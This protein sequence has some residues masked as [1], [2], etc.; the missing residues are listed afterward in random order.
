MRSFALKGDIGYSRSR[1]ELCTVTDGYAVCAGGV[2]RGVFQTLPEE[3][4]GLPVRDFTGKLILPGMVDLHIHAP[5]FE[6]RG[7]GMDLELIEWLEQRTFPVEEKYQDTEYA[8]QAYGIFA[9]QMRK[10]ATTRACIFATPHREATEVL[11]E[12][13]E[14]TGLVTYVGKVNMDRGAPAGL[15]EAGPQ[16]AAADTLG[17]IERVLG[18]YEKT[19]PILTPRF[20]PGCSE[21]L[22]AELH[23]IQAACK[24]PVQSHLSENP[25]EVELVKKLHPGIRF[26][27]Q[28][29]DR[30]GLFG[31]EAKTVMAHC[32]YSSEEEVALM[33]KNGVFAAHCPASNMN[34]SSGIAP[35]RKYLE[36]GLRVGLGSD[37]A[38]GQTESMFRAI[39]D[40]VQVSKLYWRLADQ[41]SRPLT[42]AEAFYLATLGGGEFF[43]KTGSFEAGYEFDAIVLDEKAIPSPRHNELQERIERAVYLSAD[44]TGLRAKIVRGEDVFTRGEGG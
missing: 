12:Q 36:A 8:R 22:L 33:K 42:F 39:T 4:S 34:L 29:Y 37:V 26:Y 25:G 27:G 30:F 32:V 15:Q 23:R 11:M 3:F 31:G 5:Q 13:M 35:V 43:G 7:T 2:S 9:E 28:A 19:F 38:G 14:R 41:E 21:E 40:A 24:L 10:S 16:A 20:I 1:H 18:K 44:M 17:W 6:Y